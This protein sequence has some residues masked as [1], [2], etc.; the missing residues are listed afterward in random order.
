[1]KE[2]EL[3]QICFLIISET[4]KKK[5]KKLLKVFRFVKNTKNVRLVF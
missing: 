3:L 1:L 4:E 5:V 2:A